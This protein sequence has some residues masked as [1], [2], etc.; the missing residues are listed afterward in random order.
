VSELNCESLEDR[1]IDDLPAMQAK[2]RLNGHTDW[3]TYS[4][5]P[6]F[7]Q[8]WLTDWWLLEIVALTVGTMSFLAS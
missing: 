8:R 5:G 7:S 1:R 6:S 3:K 4:N 2:G